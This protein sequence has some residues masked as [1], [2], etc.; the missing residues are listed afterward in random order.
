VYFLLYIFICIK[1]NNNNNNNKNKNKK[2]FYEILDEKTSE[3]SSKS[4]FIDGEKNGSTEI[5]SIPGP[6]ESR[7]VV[8]VL[9]ELDIEEYICRL[10]LFRQ[11]EHSLMITTSIITVPSAI[12]PMPDRM[13]TRKTCISNLPILPDN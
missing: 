1:E 7:V 4:S 8:V 12:N 2:D 5:I 13:F 3:I 6:K 11:E 9:L 10:Y